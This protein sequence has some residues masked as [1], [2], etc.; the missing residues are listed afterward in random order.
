M[1]TNLVKLNLTNNEPEDQFCLM[2]MMFS[3]AITN[4]VEEAAL[5]EFLQDHPLPWA[6][7]F[8]DLFQQGTESPL[9]MGVARLA[10]ATL[11]SWKERF[12]L[13]VPQINL[14]QRSL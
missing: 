12:E 4:G 9:Y 6:P 2:L 1:L 14:H 5:K 3:W 8:L 11:A 7:Y 10:Q 13:Q